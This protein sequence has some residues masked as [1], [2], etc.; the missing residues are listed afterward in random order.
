M[1]R[2]ALIIEYDGTDYVGWQVQPNGISVQE[3]LD[4]AFEKLIGERPVLHASGRTDS[5]VHARAQ[6]AHFDTE[7]RIPADK[8]CYAL[9][10]RLP[11]DIRVKASLEVPGD[12]HARYCVKEKHYVYTVDNAPHASA[13]MRNTALHVHYPL[14]LGKLNEAAKLFIGTHDFNAFRSSGI[15]PA[16]TERTVFVSEW[17]KEGSLLKYHV[18][19]SGFLYNMVRIM[20]GTMLRIGQG[21]DEPEVIADAL[22]HAERSYA[23]DTAPAHGLMLWRVKYDLFDTEDLIGGCGPLFVQ[24]TCANASNDVK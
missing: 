17:A 16:S 22:E 5:G 7:C 6:V 1:R 23:G 8:F 19:G 18:A 20:T 10:S 24:N 2:I 13:F 11:A 4:D 14:D 12:F 3:A 15:T 21:F 9:N